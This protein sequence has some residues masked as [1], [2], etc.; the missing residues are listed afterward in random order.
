MRVCGCLYRPS[1]R[2]T[3]RNASLVSF[4]M[5]TEKRVKYKN[6]SCGVRQENA[7]GLTL[8]FCMPL[9]PLR[10]ALKQVR[11]EFGPHSFRQLGRYQHWHG[12]GHPQH[13]GDFISFP[14]HQ[15][16]DIVI[17]VN[18]SKTIAL[19]PEEQALMPDDIYL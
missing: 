16:S 1:P 9:V 11:E 4:Q 13:C 8:L 6:C 2:D 15:L 7:N 17:G 10:S 14:Q 3:A 18:P 12:R 19:P 5:N